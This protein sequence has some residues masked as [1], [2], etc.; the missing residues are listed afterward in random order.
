MDKISRIDGTGVPLRRSNVDTDQIIPAVF[1]KRVTKTGFDDAL[2][3]NWRQ[4]PEFI[5]NQPAYASP[6][7]L[8]VGP[9]F[10]TGS[11]RSRTTASRRASARA[12][13]K[14]SAVTRASR[15]CLSPSSR[16]P[17]SSRSGSTSRATPAPR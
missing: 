2:F 11:S 6:R 9:D 4:D 3:A 15:A 7:V 1:L 17:R 16:S 10:G 5:L 14:F 13:A 12:S 8:V